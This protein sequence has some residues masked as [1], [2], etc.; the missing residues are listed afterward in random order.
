[1]PGIPPFC[2]LGGGRQS[3]LGQL[4]LSRACAYSLHGSAARPPLRLRDAGGRRPDERSRSRLQRRKALA[5]L[6]G[7]EHL[8]ISVLGGRFW[9]LPLVWLEEVLWQ[10]CTTS[11]C[12]SRVVRAC[13]PSGYAPD[14]CTSYPLRDFGPFAED[15]SGYGS[16]LGINIQGRYKKCFPLNVDGVLAMFTPSATATVAVGVEMEVVAGAT[17]PVTPIAPNSSFRSSSTIFLEAKSR[18]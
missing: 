2:V 18:D 3:S 15:G 7:R 17:E 14:T 4:G 1:L 8:H 16:L 5:Y 11:S 10:T 13:A 9:G 12:V 6:L